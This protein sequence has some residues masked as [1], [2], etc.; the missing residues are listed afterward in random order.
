MDHDLDGFRHLLGGASSLDEAPILTLADLA[1]IPAPYLALVTL[2]HDLDDAHFLVD[3]E[4]LG[5]L[6]VTGPPD[7]VRS[8]MAAMALELATSTWADD[9][10]VTVVGDF[11]A[12]EDILATGRIHYL[13]TVGRVLD[14]LAERAAEDRAAYGAR[15]S[16]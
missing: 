10:R 9:V 8:A 5:G 7:Q 4:Y 3:L 11:A 1:D 2:G 6:A 16:R 12:V 14:H 15:R 13:P